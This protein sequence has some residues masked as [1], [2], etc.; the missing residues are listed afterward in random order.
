MLW[1]FPVVTLMSASMA[2]TSIDRMRRL[3]FP[4]A[5]E[6][7]HPFCNLQLCHPEFCPSRSRTSRHGSE[8]SFYCIS[9]YRFSNVMS[10]TA[11]C[12]F[13]N[14]PSWNGSRR[15]V[16]ALL[17]DTLAGLTTETTNTPNPELLERTRS[18]V[19]TS[20]ADKISSPRSLQEPPSIVTCSD[21]PDEVAGGG[22]RCGVPTDGSPVEVNR[23]SLG[24]VGL[25]KYQAILG[26]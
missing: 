6:C 24:P 7:A 22:R 13:V 23:S 18:V 3:G 5:H 15:Q 12:V 17:V 8:V 16:A 1:H 19:R 11:H 10:A 20:R 26:V 14:P 2:I 21:P 4:G 25:F 9:Q